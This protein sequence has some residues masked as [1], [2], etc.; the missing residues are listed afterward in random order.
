MV[1]EYADD[2]LLIFVDKPVPPSVEDGPAWK[3]LIVDDEPDVHQV[4]QVALRG[5]VIE[6][7]RLEFVH[8]YSATEARSQLLNHPDLAV[9]LLDVVMEAEDAGL[10]LIRYI[11]E[12]LGNKAIRVILR[13][14]Q[15]GFAPELE[16]IRTYDINDYKTKSELTQVRLFTSLTVAIRSYWQIHQLE[17]GRQGLELI[18]AASSELSK[19]RGIQRFAEGV[20]TQLCALL[21]IGEEGLVCAAAEA[22]A[23]IPYILAAAGRYS[24]WIGQPLES[25]PDEYVRRE[26]R[27]SIAERQHRFGEA[28]CL[29]F[30]V[31][32]D[33]SLAA[34]VEVNHRL[35]EV[36]R[37]LLEVF[38]SNISIAFENTQLYQR[39][40][41]L[42]FEDSLLKLPN[43]N[44]FLVRID[45]RN[46]D[47]DRL[48]LVDIDSFA[49]INS[50]L[51]QDFGDAVLTAVANRLRDTFESRVD[52][53]RIGNDVFGILGPAAAVSEQRISDVFDEPFRLG[54]ESLRLS[55][56][57]GF[58][59]LTKDSLKAVELL[60][61]AGVALK[62]AKNFNRG[63]AAFF[64]KAHEVAARE[65]M[66]MLNRLRLAF[67][68][69]RLFLVYQP[70]IDLASG[71]VIGAEALLRWKTEGGDF[72][73]PDRFIPLAEQS[74]LMVPIG[75]W[76]TRT[77]L[78]YLKHVVDLGFT[79][80]RMAINVSHA[81]FRE[82]DFV[83]KLLAAIGDY[84]V[85]PI[86]VEIELTESV[87]IDNIDLIN[88]KLS[89]IQAAGITVAIDDF[90]TG[91]SSLSI[92]RQL[93]VN[94][95]KIDR[96]F[97]SGDDSE[98][99]DFSIAEMIL[100]LAS[101]LELETIAEGIETQG[102]LEKMRSMGCDDGQGYLFSKPLSG[103]SFDEFLQGKLN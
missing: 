59:K 52:V 47:A 55:A 7:R 41:N 6:D 58:V 5:I 2:D 79:D 46:E 81:Q 100:K 19:P 40:S 95:L 89:V 61:N 50:I 102:Q 29:F 74:G 42:A 17:A 31:P 45:L 10:K 98:S 44:S 91:F 67:S 77:A 4:T 34:Y 35:N 36:D 72:V 51:D 60:R 39:I 85:Q 66:A 53:A 90:G 49:E 27:L 88:E 16:T 73:P 62:Q 80:F 25:I 9:V 97:V 1:S 22:S 15:P 93:H 101:Q 56:T 20:V 38:C 75:D 83:E 76:I 3:I 33:Y 48:A 82:P 43:R 30:N 68:A 99:D 92:L 96:S 13:T 78:Q 69:E 12:D 64:E 70:F 63:K 86:N 57:T 71:Q 94:R 54:N 103:E 32:G 87:A 28:T 23:S 18:V 26:L 11:R 24:E 65:R 84:G 37:N 8:A 14:G 21:G